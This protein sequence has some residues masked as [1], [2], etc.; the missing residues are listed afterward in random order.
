MI[1]QKYYELLIVLSH[2]AG[3]GKVRFEPVGDVTMAMFVLKDAEA[4]GVDMSTL[5]TEDVYAFARL[6]ADVQYRRI[7]D[8]RRQRIMELRELYTF[9][10]AKEWVIRDDPGFFT[11]LTD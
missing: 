8:S 11:V 1:D 9:M 6:M 2:F 10:E 3:F 4:L 5:T 7:L